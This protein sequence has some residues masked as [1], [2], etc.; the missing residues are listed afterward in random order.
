PSSRKKAPMTTP[1]TPRTPMGTRDPN[2]SP[3]RMSDLPEE[4]QFLQSK[5]QKKAKALNLTLIRVQKV[6]R[7]RD[8]LNEVLL[9]EPNREIR[10]EI[11]E[12]VKKLDF[13][14]QNLKKGDPKASQALYRDIYNWAQKIS[15][16]GVQIH[17][18]WV[19]GHIGI[20]RNAKADEY[21]KYRAN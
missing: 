9:D 13:I 11:Q 20:Y 5:A 15:E 16:K 17:L 12:E 8:L 4:D 1:K 10:A 18:A 6:S 7:A 14:L 21:T 19:P 2:S 3:F